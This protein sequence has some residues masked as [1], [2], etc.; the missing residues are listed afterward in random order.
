MIT[1]H[2]RTLSM[3]SLIYT[4][5][6]ESINK[7]ALS[8]P[9][10]NIMYSKSP[11]R[12]AYNTNNRIRHVRGKY[13]VREEVIKRVEVNHPCKL[14]RTAVKVTFPSMKS[15]VLVS[16]IGYKEPRW[17]IYPNTSIVTISLKVVDYNTINI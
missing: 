10:Y 8:I 17:N 3:A 12:L 5:S 11:P 4:L 16:F 13:T 1:L 6:S 9:S 15:E 7:H 14:T 2:T